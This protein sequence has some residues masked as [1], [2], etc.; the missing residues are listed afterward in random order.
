[1]KRQT[2]HQRARTA[3]VNG[4]SKGGNSIQNGLSHL[5]GFWR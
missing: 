2:F 4:N 5:S 1:M 3:Q